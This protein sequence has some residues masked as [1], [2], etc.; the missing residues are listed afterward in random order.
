MKRASKLALAGVG[1]LAI[2]GVMAAWSTPSALPA[3][4]AMNAAAL[5]ADPADAFKVDPVHSSVVFKIA[6]LNVSHFYGR[7]NKIDGSFNLNAAQPSAS[8]LSISI[9]TDS[10]DSNNGGRDNHLKS[11]DFFSAKEFP[12][13]SFEG[14]KFEKKD[15]GFEVTGD[16]TLH[17]QTKPVTVMIEETGTGKGMKGESIAGIASTFTIKRSD[18]GVGA[19]KFEGALGEE[20]TIMVGLEGAKK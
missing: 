18:F 8:T 4:A 13:I 1:G 6:H 9:E 16:L 11:Q 2:A 15:K 7:F 5:A 14:K 20:V 17:G 3:A 19:K 12:K 10:I